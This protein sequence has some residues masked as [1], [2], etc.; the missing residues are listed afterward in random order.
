MKVLS[1]IVA[2]VRSIKRTP[3]FQVAGHF[4]K[5]YEENLFRG[6]ESRSGTGSS[7]VQT[8]TIREKLPDLLQ[9]FSV[10]S[11]LDAPCGDCNWIAQLDW[12]RVAYTGADVVGKLIQS[13]RETF[14]GKPMNF[15]AVDLCQD[16]LPRS[17][18]IL[19]RDCWV[20]LDYSQIRACLA[21]FR[22]S[23]AK[24][25]LTTTFTKRRRNRDLGGDL[26]RPINLQAGPF[27]FPQ[28][29]AMLVEGCTEDGGNYADKT[30]GLWELREL[31]G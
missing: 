1:R 14:S 11:I 22:Q 7:L 6:D 2:A 20:H 26:W 19:C 9:R 21:N 24:Y 10:T 18:L 25:L 3:S 23:G 27:K 13:N 5:I 16:P 17:D 30:L 31:A 8:A 4:E 12:S 15:T 28:P 29:L